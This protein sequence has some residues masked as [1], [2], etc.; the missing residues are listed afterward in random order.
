MTKLYSPSRNITYFCGGEDNSTIWKS[1]DGLRVATG[2]GCSA[3][4]WFV[5]TSISIVG[6][7]SY[8]SGIY[9]CSL[10]NNTA[11]WFNGWSSKDQDDVTLCKATSLDSGN[12]SIS[13]INGPLPGWSVALDYFESSLSSSSSASSNSSN[14]TMSQSNST[15]SSNTTSSASDDSKTSNSVFTSANPYYDLSSTIYA[16]TISTHASWERFDWWLDGSVQE[17]IPRREE[18]AAREQFVGL[19]L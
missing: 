7:T 13:L 3:T 2:A 10:D 1:S 17:E 4:T 9:G 5:G 11:T 15:S 16:P 6:P 12:H 19:G 18:E 8:K 14:A